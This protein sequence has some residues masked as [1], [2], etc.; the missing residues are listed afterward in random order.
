[1]PK[2]KKPKKRKATLKGCDR[3]RSK[4]I[5]IRAKFRCE[6]CWSTKWLNSHH[7]FT[8]NNYSTRF[9]LDNWICLCALH[10]KLSTKFSAH[11]TP[12][13]FDEWII[14]ERWQERFDNLRAK[15]N[16]TRDR[17]YERVHDYLIEETKKLIT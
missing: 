14:S 8:R 11:W 2:A 4:L 6:Y 12:M 10:H 13:I 5:K 9:D 17:N 16:K 15:A 7:L 3:L 1:M